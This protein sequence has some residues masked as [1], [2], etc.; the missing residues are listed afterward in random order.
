MTSYPTAGRLGDTT[1]TLTRQAIT[2]PTRQGW[3]AATC[4]DTDTVPMPALVVRV[5]GASGAGATPVQGLLVG[6]GDGE[7]DGVVVGVGVALDGL[8]WIR[9]AGRRVGTA[10]R[11]VRG[12]RE[13]G[14]G[15]EDP[16]MDSAYVAVAW[17]P[18]GAAGGG[19]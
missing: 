13:W 18:P 2:A 12:L 4:H 14:G 7:R 9:R 16:G 10:G 3:L 19:R 1:V 17:D 8:P 6:D 15:W 5:V 11:G